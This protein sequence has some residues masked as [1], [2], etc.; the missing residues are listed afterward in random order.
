M[1]TRRITTT[2]T[3]SEALLLFPMR[4]TNRVSETRLW[5]AEVSSTMAYEALARKG[6]V[7]RI[8]LEEHA[9]GTHIF[10]FRRPDSPWPEE[11]H[12]QDS[13]EIAMC[14]CEHDYDVPRDAWK[15]IPNPGLA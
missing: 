15:E 3:D 14:A 8:A 10:V 7:Y 12:L 1:A 9:E 13:L 6:D 11:D 4:R 2:L 5:R